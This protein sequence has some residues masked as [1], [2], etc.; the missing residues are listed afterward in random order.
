M[1]LYRSL[2][3]PSIVTVLIL[4]RIIFFLERNQNSAVFL[5]QYE[6][7]VHNTLMF[8][9]LL[10]LKSR[11]FVSHALPASRYARHWEGAWPEELTQL[12][13]SQ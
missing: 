1:S 8:Q 12:A 6:N 3:I 13:K 9:L 4:S 5:V 7:D 11:T 10:T 2:T